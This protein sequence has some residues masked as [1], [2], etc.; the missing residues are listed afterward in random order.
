[1]PASS[2]SSAAGAWVFCLEGIQGAQGP[3][4][5][6]VYQELLQVWYALGPSSQQVATAH[7]T[8]G[9]SA[10]MKLMRSASM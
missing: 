8:E 7:F 4:S 1:M 5:M 2:V 10:L 6:K 9:Y 3:P